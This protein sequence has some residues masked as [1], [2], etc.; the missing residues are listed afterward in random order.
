M[1]M[2]S[3]EEVRRHRM[4]KLVT[5]DGDLVPLCVF[6]GDRQACLDIS[7]RLANVFPIESLAAFVE[8]IQECE[9]KHLLDV[10]GRVTLGDAGKLLAPARSVESWIVLLLVEV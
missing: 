4:S 6:D 1:G 2:V 7:H 5:S 3:F 9:R 10:G 8:C